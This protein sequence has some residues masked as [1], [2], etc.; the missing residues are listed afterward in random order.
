MVKEP[1]NFSNPIILCSVLPLVNSIE[2]IRVSIVL[3]VVLFESSVVLSIVLGARLG[4]TWSVLG[5][6]LSGFSSCLDDS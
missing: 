1:S 3:S 5:R 2:L 4:D 6:W